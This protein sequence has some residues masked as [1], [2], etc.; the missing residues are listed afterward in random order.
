MENAVP[1]IINSRIK[2]RETKKAHI[3]Y[4][5]RFLE[6]VESPQGFFYFK[7]KDKE[8]VEVK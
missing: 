5:Y 1:Y 6:G 4:L 3:R 8:K 2:N 7:Q